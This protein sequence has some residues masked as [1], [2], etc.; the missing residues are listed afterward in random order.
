MTPVRHLHA[1]VASL[2]GVFAFGA[3]LAAFVTLIGTHDLENYNHSF[4]SLDRGTRME[5]IKVFGQP[6]YTFELALGCDC[7]FTAIWVRHQRQSWRH[8]FRSRLLTGCCS[9][10]QWAQRR[11]LSGTRSNLSAAV[12]SAGSFAG[13]T[14][15]A[16][17]VVDARCS[18]HQ[19]DP[20]RR[21]CQP[22][23]VRPTM[24]VSAKCEL[25]TGP[26]SRYVSYLCVTFAYSADTKVSGDAVAG[27]DAVVRMPPR[28]QTRTVRGGRLTLDICAIEGEG[29]LS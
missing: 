29:G 28:L 2:M 10:W 12:C 5:M 9:R 17:R 1:G 15:H 6:V 3:V 13:H 23:K 21:T 19:A 24:S 4:F 11:S 27:L 20:A 16:H 14:R 22:S 26:L 18:R 25:R 7:R 8:V